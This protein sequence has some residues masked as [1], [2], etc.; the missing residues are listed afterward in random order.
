M[1]SDRPRRRRDGRTGSLYC[2]DCGAP[3][4]PTMRYCPDCGAMIARSSR[5]SRSAAT[6]LSRPGTE[7]RPRADTS[8]E[9][10]GT[11]GR[12]SN[13]ATDRDRLERR[14]AAASRDGWRLEHDFGDHAVLLRRTF[15]GLADHLAV[16]LLTGWW[17]M[18]IG[19]VLY[20][21]YRY[22]DGTERTVVRAEPV[23][24]DQPDDTTTD[25][26]LFRR[27]LAVLGWLLAALTVAI[28]VQLGVSAVGLGLFA[29]AL[30]LAIAVT[31][32]LPSVSG[33]LENRHSVLTNG[34]THTVD[35]RTVVA[36]DDPCA[37]CA[38]P[39]DRG[40]ERRYR[41]EVCVLG[42]PVT[43]TGGRNYYCRQCANAESA[44]TA[45]GEHALA[46]EPEPND[47]SAEPNA[48]RDHV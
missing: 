37:A 41:A 20:G 12:N 40:L 46:V 33:R 18:G 43:A 28:G 15:G 42:V 8:R 17:T 38:G 22:V 35:D 45:A 19:N 16:A 32:V 2:T 6:S 13:P 1:R 34:R 21:A 36:P 7:H 14:I 10:A 30:G 3:L 25:S 23:D 26:T 27:G 4:E 11:S 47:S 44:A 39:I 31:S 5:R 9:P 24:T 48:E 29:L